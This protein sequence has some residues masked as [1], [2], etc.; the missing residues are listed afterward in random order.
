MSKYV[1]EIDSIDG[2]RNTPT[3]DA[4]AAHVRTPSGQSG[5]FVPMDGDPFGRGDDGA[6]AL[7]ARDGAWWARK[8]ALSDGVLRAEWWGVSEDNT[9]QENDEAFKALFSSVINLSRR[10]ILPGGTI[11]I[12][13]PIF[14][15]GGTENPS[16]NYHIEGAQKRLTT[17]QKTSSTTVNAPL[18]QKNP[19]ACFVFD[20]DPGDGLIGSITPATGLRVENIN[21]AGDQRGQDAIWIG[22]WRSGEINNIRAF[23]C[24]SAVTFGEGFN[25]RVSQANAVSCNHCVRARGDG[26]STSVLIESCYADDIWEVGFLLEDTTYSTILSCAADGAGRHG[27]LDSGYRL[28][29]CFGI[30][31]SSCGAEFI[32]EHGIGCF[33]ES[34]QQ[35]TLTAFTIV[36]EFESGRTSQG[37]TVGVYATGSG[38][39]VQCESIYITNF[40][41]NEATGT[42]ISS[43]SFGVWATGGNEIIVSQGSRLPGNGT[44]TRSQVVDQRGRPSLSSE[45]GSTVDGTYGT[46]ESN[47]IDRNRTRIQEIE[48]ALQ[49]YGVLS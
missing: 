47:V 7:Q 42:V 33:F 27:E 25:V 46:E 28:K 23:E 20:G 22:A 10:I 13:E 9:P 37:P 31:I 34:S 41:E 15:D 29:D 18:A 6:V 3:S 43:Q 32:E 39:Q 35:V 14:V 8:E 11:K 48:A 4:A 12:D 44:A 30:E 16:S 21:F 45:D 2:L 1:R 40:D 24:G 36:G 26:F 17:I 38:S 49:E 5:L 19:N